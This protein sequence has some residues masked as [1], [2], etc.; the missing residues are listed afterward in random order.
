MGLFL[1]QNSSRNWEGQLR[2]RSSKQ[3]AWVWETCMI[4]MFVEPCWI[5]HYMDN[6]LMIT[7]QGM[8]FYCLLRRCIFVG[9]TCIDKI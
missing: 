9:E 7:F 5:C 3:Q 4:G 6:K 1:Q 8:V 2:L